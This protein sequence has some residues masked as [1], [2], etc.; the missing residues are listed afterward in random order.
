MNLALK[1][2]IVNPLELFALTALV[3]IAYLV[4]TAR[5][6]M[7]QTI[8]VKTRGTTELV[9]IFVLMIYNV[10]KISGKDIGA[11]L[12]P[13]VITHVLRVTIVLMGVCVTMEHAM[14]GIALVIPIARVKFA[15]I[16]LADRVLICLTA[17]A[18]GIQLLFGVRKVDT[19]K[20]LIVVQ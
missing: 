2:P 16:I 17:R 6:T 4:L 8:G 15:K 7:A 1:I 20:K 11:A 10:L 19:V 3:H 12:I 18:M 14:L 13:L 9:Q 5:A